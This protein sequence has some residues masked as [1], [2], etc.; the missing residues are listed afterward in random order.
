[1]SRGVR[2]YLRLFSLYLKQRYSL[3]FL[4][5]LLVAIVVEAVASALVNVAYLTPAYPVPYIAD[6]YVGF[7]VFLDL[8]VLL[9]V[10]MTVFSAPTYFSRSEMEFMFTTQYNPLTLVFIKLIG[11]G[12]YLDLLLVVLT[13]GFAFHFAFITHQLVLIPLYFINVI[14]IGII[15]SGLLLYL[16]V[17]STPIKVVSSLLLALYL[18]TS[19]LLNVTTNILFSA[20]EPLPQY[21]VILLTALLIMMIPM[22]RLAREI[23][24]NAYGIHQSHEVRGYRSLFRGIRSAFGA[25]LVTSMYSQV[26][27]RRAIARVRVNTLLISA[28]LSASF[29]VLYGLVV[30]RNRADLGFTNFII[31]YAP[32]YVML[33][34]SLILGST[35]SFE[36]PWIN[37]T[38]GVDYMAY[39]RL[40][41]GSRLLITYL[42][43]LPWA[44][45]SVALYCLVHDVALLMITVPLISYPL[46]LVPISWILM[47]LSDIPQT[48]DLT[49]DYRPLR[50]S[51]GGM[52]SGVVVAIIIGALLMPVLVYQQ[53]YL[54]A[55]SPWIAL[56]LELSLSAL[57]YM[58]LMYSRVGE[59]V[60]RWL[61]E[62]L[63]V[64]G[65]S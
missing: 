56:I 7:M 55:T 35:L 58:V 18:L 43:V 5:I 52:F 48:R 45:V 47:A 22:S 8:V 16:H 62:K 11:D 26:M 3:W 41:M 30:V 49:F 9:T 34:T 29:A 65:Y 51:V 31:Y 60:W 53:L 12:V 33:M 44:L 50:F 15:F 39:L 1:M 2:E 32:F 46:P 10:V 27:G 61:V 17:A 4:L 59:G 64:L 19:T 23:S 6:Q 24:L 42:V 28:L 14:I 37:F 20:I 63:S 21:T 57:T 13:L 54:H 38:S 40:R 36:R 25:V